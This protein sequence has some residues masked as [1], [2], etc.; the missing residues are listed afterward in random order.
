MSS[1]SHHP[2]KFIPLVEV[3]KSSNHVCRWRP[4]ADLTKSNQGEQAARQVKHSANSPD[5]EA[6][7]ASKP[8]LH[9]CRMKEISAGIQHRQPSSDMPCSWVLLCTPA[10]TPTVTRWDNSA[11]GS[12]KYL[13]SRPFKDKSCPFINKQS[14][15]LLLLQDTHASLLFSVPTKHRASHPC[16]ERLGASEWLQTV[17]K[18]RWSN[19]ENCKYHQEMMLTSSQQLG[20]RSLSTH[21]FLAFISARESV[22]LPKYFISRSRALLCHELEILVSMKPD[23][24]ATPQLTSGQEQ[25][26]NITHSRT[27]KHAIQRRHIHDA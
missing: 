11:P 6:S 21:A 16:T 8:L 18:Y 26:T 27:L 20:R 14:Q 10:E 24:G 25:S 12:S 17:Y 19:T 23:V 7:D 4:K 1:W 3:L 13:S 15:T 9:R 22:L 5:K 2:C